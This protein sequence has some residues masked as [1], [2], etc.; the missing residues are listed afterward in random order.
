MIKLSSFKS[1]KWYLSALLSL[2]VVSFFITSPHPSALAA[3]KPIKIGIS[4]IVEHPALNAVRDAVIDV[5][6]ES[7]MVQGEDVIF[8][9][10]NAQGSFSDAVS[11]AQTF[12]AQGVDIV[13][14]I[15]TP[16]AQAAVQVIKNKP[17]VVSAV[18][19]FVQAG[20]VEDYESYDN[21]EDNGN[22]TGVTDMTPVREQLELLQK[23][24]PELQ[25]I[26]IVYNPGEANSKY[27]TGVANEEADKMGLEIVEATATNTSEVGMA[28][29]SL[30]GRVG[31]IWVST[32]NTVVS[33]LPV[34]AQVA[35]DEDIP[36]VTADPTTIELGPLAAFGWNYYR[37][38]RLA[39]EVVLRI[40]RGERPN[41]IPIQKLEG[42]PETLK[43]ALNLDTA[44]EI[45]LDLPDETREQA[46]QLVFG[47]RVWEPVK[48][49]EK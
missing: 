39:G 43:M 2:L 33:A 10:K 36:L 35:W 38:G 7:G 8:L 5:V 27:L 12:K 3:E 22:V 41:E 14:P 26:G 30:K 6:T 47:G 25:K 21:P 24:N 28:A 20:L 15:A 17:I 49:V 4:Q 32:D 18:T 48:E 42:M 11:I 9:T 16:T 1:R 19:D 46:D 45:G 40:I 23:L 37:H 34:V 44:R 31:G 13:V 29:E